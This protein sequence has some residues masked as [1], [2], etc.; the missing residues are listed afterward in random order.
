MAAEVVDEIEMRG[1]TGL[2]QHAPGIAAHREHPPGFDG[3]VLV[4]RETLFVS[5]NAAPVDHRLAVVLAVRL[6]LRLENLSDAGLRA[7][8]IL[9][10]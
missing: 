5:C 9:L 3:M 6:Q 7:V 8:L 4:Q 1:K 10:R 2:V